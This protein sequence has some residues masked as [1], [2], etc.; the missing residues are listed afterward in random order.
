MKIVKTNKPEEKKLTEEETP[1]ED[2]VELDNAT[3]KEIAADI[4]QGAAEAGKQVKDQAALQQ[5][6]KDVYETADLIENPY[7]TAQLDEIKT[8]L[9]MAL[10][11]AIADRE[12]GETDISESVNVLIYGLAGFG[13]TSIVKQF[14]R[15]HHLNMFECDAKSLDI[16]TVGGIPY[17]SPDANGTLKQTPVVSDYWET[18]SRPNT[19][20]F[21]DELNRARG[22]IIGSLLTL[23]NEHTLPG[24]TRD[25]NGRVISNIRRFPNILFTVSAINPASDV[26][27]DAQQ[28]DPA[29]VSRNAFVIEHAPNTAAFKKHIDTLYK[30]IEK[31]KF[32]SPK[33]Q[34]RYAGQHAIADKI[35]TDKAFIQDG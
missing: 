19:V 12:L 24:V 20:L 11:A 5:H 28:L 1:E 14:C 29:M 8:A 23:I 9:Q 3:P 31:N 7:G 4:E 30:A 22:N 16:A 34:Q 10:E 6:V 26:F 32:L 2:V 33:S 27:E 15:E 21:L 18:L 13:K 25:P 35:L 17:P